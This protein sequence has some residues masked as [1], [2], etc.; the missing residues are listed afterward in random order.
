MQNITSANSMNFNERNYNTR[1]N[2]TPSPDILKTIDDVALQYLLKVQAREK[3]PPSLIDLNN[4]IYS[5]AVSENHYLDQLI[6]NKDGNN[7][8][9]TELSRWLAYLQ[10]SINRTRREI[11]HIM[12]ITECR[13]KNQYTKKQKDRLRKKF[14]DIKDTT[15]DYK[16]IFLKHDL[17]A[18]SEKMKP[19]RN[20]METKCLNRKFACDPKS[21]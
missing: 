13:M 7:K 10:D 1:V 9:Q 11:A 5:V 8:K 17:K 19:H 6:E 15:L 21:L 3:W 4:Y 18:K 2:K 16:L 12:T 20:K 14:G